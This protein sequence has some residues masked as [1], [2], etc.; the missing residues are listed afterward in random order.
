MEDKPGG[1]SMGYRLE[2]G[3]LWAY[4]EDGREP[5]LVASDVAEMTYNEAEYIILKR[6]GTLL[7]VAI[8]PGEYLEFPY[9]GVVETLPIKGQGW[10]AAPTEVE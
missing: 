3:D 10:A 5:R 8:E 9:D 7:R 4:A 1:N 6:D 2:D